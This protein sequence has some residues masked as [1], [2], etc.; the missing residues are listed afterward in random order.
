LGPAP[1]AS[2]NRNQGKCLGTKPG[3][4]QYLRQVVYTTAGIIG[5]AVTALGIAIPG[6]VDDWFQ[7]AAGIAA[8][9]SGALAAV[10]TGEHSDYRPTGRP[11]DADTQ[12][13]DNNT[14]HAPQTPP[15]PP[16][17]YTPTTPTNDAYQPPRSTITPQGGTPGHP[18]PAPEH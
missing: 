2:N 7:T 5:L 14:L 11:K 17:T 1:A 18:T 6:Q 16:V 10:S 8:A 13:G 4:L 3:A 12:P 15:S 9:V